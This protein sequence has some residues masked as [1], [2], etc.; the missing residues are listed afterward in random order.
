MNTTI[1]TSLALILGLAC[2][3]V[4]YAAADNTTAANTAQNTTNAASEM[5]D[6]FTIKNSQVMITENGET[7]LM[8]DDMKLADGI[9]VRTDGSLIVP[10]GSRR[11]LNEGDSMTFEGTIT[12]AGT[13][14]VEQLHPR[15]G[16]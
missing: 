12:R 11:V 16:P 1:K 4:S 6:G 8:T 9:E 3:S 5:R 13:G 15:T 2:V 14:K 10:G 7:K